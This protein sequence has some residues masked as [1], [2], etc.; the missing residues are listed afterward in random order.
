LLHKITGV[1]LT[2]IPGIEANTAL[3]L[4]GEIGRD[5]SR[6]PSAKHFASWLCLCPGNKISGGRVL[7]SKT[8][9]SKNRAAAALRMAAQ[10]LERTDTALGAFYRKIK[11]RKDAPKAI[12]ATAHKLAILVYTMLK[13]GESYVDIGQ[14]AYEKQYEAR[15][16]ASVKRRAAKLG[17]QIVPAIPATA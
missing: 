4:I 10:C 15:V 7:S 14:E 5:I 3:K 6:W 12:T 16:L 1:D 2:Q 8:R 9:N 11:S 17:Y 13:K